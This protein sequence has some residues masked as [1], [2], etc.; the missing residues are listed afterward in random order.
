MID[1]VIDR[2]R[3]LR[4]E[5]SNQSYLLRK[6][7]QK[8]CCVG[9]LC[10]ALGYEPGEIE[11]LVEMRELDCSDQDKLQDSLYCLG[12]GSYGDSILGSLYVV[13]DQHDL[14]NREQEI[15]S[16]GQ[17]LNVNFTFVN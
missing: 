11:G 5:G 10:Q 15:I 7:D 14:P 16:L 4:G 12:I 1:V 8:M 17:Q 9:F 13:N 3:W 6:D 2:S